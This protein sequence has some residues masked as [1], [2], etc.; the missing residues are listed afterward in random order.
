MRASN[1]V[2]RPTTTRHDPTLFAAGFEILSADFAL[3]LTPTCI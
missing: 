1:R 2:F 3:F